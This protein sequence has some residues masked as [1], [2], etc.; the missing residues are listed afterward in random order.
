[1]ILIHILC[2]KN[3][4]KE[5]HVESAKLFHIH[6]CIMFKTIMIILVYFC[7]IC[8]TDVNECDMNV[9]LCAPREVNQCINTQGSYMCNCSAEYGYFFV[10]SIGTCSKGLF[11]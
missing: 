9:E 10:E 2:V 7:N 3:T 11:K 8:Y 4:A 6:V 5:P 1:M